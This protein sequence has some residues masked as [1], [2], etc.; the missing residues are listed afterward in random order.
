ML[1]NQSIIIEQAKF[2]YYPLGKV[3]EKQTKTIE[4]QNKKQIKSLEEHGK[5]LIKSSSEKDSLERLKQKEIFD[6]LLNETKFEIN[7]SSEEIDFNNS[8]YYYTGKSARKYFVHFKGPF[9][10]YNDIRNYRISLQKEGKS[11]EEFRSK[12]NKIIKGNPNYKSEYQINT[13]KNI[14]KLYNGW[15][16]V[17]KFHNYYTRMVSDDIYKSIHGEGLK[18]LTPKQ[19]IQRLTIALSQVKAGNTS[20]N[21]LNEIRQIIYSLYQA[22][23]IT[24]KVYN[25]IMN[26]MKV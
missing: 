1:S 9:I 20:E 2:T 3:F 25:N 19:V 26:S 15:E 13:I 24:K 23:E 4:E 16:K 10:M 6:D 14:K 22:D 17:L 12:L 7:K 11:Q 8:N 21:L 18:I 5:N